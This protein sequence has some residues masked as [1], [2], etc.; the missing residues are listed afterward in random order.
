MSNYWIKSGIFS[1]LDRL[2]GVLFG[3]GGVY[4]LLRGLSKADFGVWTLFLTVN[5]I[6]EMARIG[7]IQNALI[8]YTASEENAAIRPTIN[9]AS[10]AL[11][12]IVTAANIGLFLISAPILAYIWQSPEIAPMLYLCA[13]TT[14]LLLPLSQCNF[15]Q[16]AH[17]D[18]AAPFWASLMRQGSFFAYLLYCHFAQQTLT[19]YELAVLNTVT[20]LLAAIVAVVL[21]RRHWNFAP[22]ID[23][24]WLRTLFNFGKYVFGTNLSSMI[25]K[26]V[27]KI[28]LGSLAGTASVA[29][30]D[31]AIRINNLIEI[32]TLSIAAIVFPKSAQKIDTEGKPAIKALYEQ[33]VGVMLALIIPAAILVVFFAEPIVQI[34]AGEKYLDA[35]P[36]LRL[37]I[38]FSLLLP[39]GMQFG[40]TFDAIGKPRTNF[41]MV[42]FSTLLN[43]LLNYFFIQRWGIYGSVYATLITLSVGF[44]VTQILV[45]RELNA[46][47][48]QSFWHIKTVYAAIWQML[49]RQLST[50]DPIP[51]EPSTV[52]PN[53]I[54]SKTVAAKTENSIATQQ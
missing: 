50:R 49:R 12:T 19:L 11:N 1:L 29:V 21:C 42:L 13:I 10:L 46:N 48:L 15:I 34:I 7:L 38:L 5:A 44:V 37:T 25:H 3:F 47:P 20:T 51:I 22:H 39:F 26:N 52:P 8:K 53:N 18:F 16:Q 35:V 27:D 2:T 40:T 23:W 33:S 32:P 4:L 54:P 36:I 24:Q 41:Y 9:T 17:F 14:V 31:L 45:Y 6:F 30:Y 43:A 28:M